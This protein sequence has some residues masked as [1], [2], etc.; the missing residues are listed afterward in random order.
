MARGRAAESRIDFP[1]Q[2]ARPR[3]GTPGWQDQTVMASRR[4][5]HLQAG[6]IYPQTHHPK[7]LKI[8]SQCV[9]TFTQDME[10]LAI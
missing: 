3:F 8:S 6:H 7:E 2:E 5:K 4:C 9:P 1:Q 10:C